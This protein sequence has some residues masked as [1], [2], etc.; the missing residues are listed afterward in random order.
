[1]SKVVILAGGKGT[2]ISEETKTIPKP[3]I[4]V[5]DKPLLHHIMDSYIAQG[6]NEFIIP[7]GYKSEI[8]IGYFLGIPNYFVD[9]HSGF[10]TIGLGN[11]LV[12]IVNSGMETQTGGRLKRI[13]EFIDDDFFFTYGDGLA[14]L[15]I[16]KVM[17]KH[18]DV[19]AIATISAVRPSPRF[20][21]LLFDGNGKI[22]DF[23]EKQEHLRGWING[24]FAAMSPEI[25]SYISGDDVNL[26]K[27]IYPFLAYR[28]KMYA[29]EHNGFW[30]CVDTIRDLEEIENIYNEQGAIWLKR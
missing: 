29:V 27:D 10:M 6:L 17:K 24:G 8:I 15:D 23:G 1:M 19:E 2:R 13:E 18:K 4:R 9:Y 16:H 25:F 20:G 21:S 7:V 12:T 22:A 30:Q 26:E 14:D 3:M 5:G 11:C 28:D